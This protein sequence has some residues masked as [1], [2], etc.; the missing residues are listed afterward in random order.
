MRFFWALFWTF[1]LAAMLTYV[2]G[3]MSGIAFNLTTAG[4][5]TV[6]AVIVILL[7]SVVLPEDSKSDH[8]AH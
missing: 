8:A 7:I 2:V 6:V 5:L 4:I 1:L 3:S